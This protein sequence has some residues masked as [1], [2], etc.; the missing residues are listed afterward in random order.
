MG[1]VLKGILKALTPVNEGITNTFVKTKADILFQLNLNPLLLGVPLNHKLT[2]DH[3][4]LPY[5]LI[6]NISL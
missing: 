5:W 4:L 1:L 3:F 2:R 6:V